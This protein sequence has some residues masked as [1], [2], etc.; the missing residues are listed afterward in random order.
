MKVC[1]HSLCAARGGMQ[2]RELTGVLVVAVLLDVLS[3][4]SGGHAV[5][6]CDVHSLAGAVAAIAAHNEL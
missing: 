4:E 2:A 1:C 3:D 5:V 6:A